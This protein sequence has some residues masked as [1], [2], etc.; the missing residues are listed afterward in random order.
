MSDERGEAGVGTRGMREREEGWGG[1]GREGVEEGVEQDFHR[2][3]HR[4]T[5]SR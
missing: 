1:L 3:T 5:S 4:F 2:H